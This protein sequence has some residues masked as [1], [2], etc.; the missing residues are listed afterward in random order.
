MDSRNPYDK[1]IVRNFKEVFFARLPRSKVDFRAEIES[2]WY[3]LAT[4][5]EV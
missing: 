4:N 5:T 1:G 2:I 3:P